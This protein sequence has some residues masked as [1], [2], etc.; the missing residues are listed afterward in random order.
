M[1]E[2]RDDKLLRYCGT[3][4]TVVIP[5]GVK[6]V[7]KEAFKDNWAVETVVFSD[8]EV[9]ERGAFQN[10]QRL[11]AVTFSETLREINAY[12]FED[13][14]S[15]RTI[16]FYS[17]VEVYSGA[18]RGCHLAE[19]KVPAKEFVADATLQLAAGVCL[20]C[21][22]GT[23]EQLADGS[24]KCP[25]CGHIYTTEEQWEARFFLISNG[26]LVSYNGGA[27]ECRIPKGVKRIGAYAFDDMACTQLRIPSTVKV[28]EPFAFQWFRTVSEVE[29]AVKRVEHHAFAE[30][31]APTIKLDNQVEY[32]GADALAGTRLLDFTCPNL[33]YLGNGAL[34]RTSYLRQATISPS[35]RAVGDYAFY[36]SGI[37]TV[38]IKGALS[39]G[40][41]AFWGCRHLS[42]L[43]LGDDLLTIGEEAFAECYSLEFVR[44]PSSCQ[45]IGRKAFQNCFS[46]KALKLPYA[47][48]T[49][50][51]EWLGLPEQ[52]QVEFV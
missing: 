51:K 21:S 50:S 25:Q 9:I 26:E 29:I 36:L 15:L 19:A 34:Q 2:I 43:E 14:I 41:Y 3:D 1:F 10:C 48:H 13:C 39:I 6:V 23:T 46:L 5:Y 7:G 24:R 45:Y 52:T 28:I 33:K 30:T 49:F 11:S 12:A 31:S 22:D 4:S 37:Q 42:F 20:M 40:E 16:E 27:C 38:H 18:F 8:V 32:V 17:Q 47:L 44:I 35:T